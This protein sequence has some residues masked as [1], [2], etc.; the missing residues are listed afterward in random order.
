M[1]DLNWSGDITYGDF[2]VTV[3]TALLC[4]IVAIVSL[5]AFFIFTFQRRK[6][7]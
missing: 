2:S 1:P 4:L 3:T 6:K 5:G 7:Q